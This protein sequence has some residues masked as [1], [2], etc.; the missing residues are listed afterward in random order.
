MCDESLKVVFL[1]DANVGKTSIINRA[2]KGMFTDEIQETIGA[3]CQ[4]KTI[5]IDGND[6]TL[7]IWDTAG[8]EKFRSLAPMYYRGAAAVILVYS[9]TDLNSFQELN[10]WINDL[11]QNGS[12]QILFI[13]G[14]KADLEDQRVISTEDGESFA[15][16]VSATFFEVSAKVGTSIEE[17]F[18]SVALEAHQQALIPAADDNKP[19]PQGV[20]LEKTNDQAA[21]NQKCGC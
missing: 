20:L 8:Q 21:N 2:L 10:T 9:I 17:L 4:Q 13:V 3:Y 6:V 5:D 14:N 16:N 11:K 18:S 1:G 12:P 15:K 7:D 19:P